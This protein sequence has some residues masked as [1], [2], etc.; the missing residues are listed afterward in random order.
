MVRPGCTDVIDLRRKLVNNTC[1]RY[2]L[3]S[4]SVFE[5]GW[6]EAVHQLKPRP[7]LAEGVLPYFEEEQVK[8]LVL[9]LR[10]YFPCSE[11]V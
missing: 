3:L 9:K 4:A 1:E 2:H 6:L 8:S 7:F 11:L 5:D 10:N